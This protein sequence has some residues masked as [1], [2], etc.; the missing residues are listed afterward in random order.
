MDGDERTRRNRRPADKE[1]A[2]EG[3]TQSSLDLRGDT[4]D[5]LEAAIKAHTLGMVRM[6]G[7]YERSKVDATR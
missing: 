7:R 2:D 3:G 6:M 1:S 5:D 4:R